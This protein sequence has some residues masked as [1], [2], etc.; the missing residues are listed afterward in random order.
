MKEK[1]I[2]LSEVV[3]AVLALQAERDELRTTSLELRQACLAYLSDHGGNEPHRR[4]A[5]RRLHRA[6]DRSSG[7]G[8]A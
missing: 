5:L 4:K 8:S 2:S 3:D 1:K 6:I 7:L